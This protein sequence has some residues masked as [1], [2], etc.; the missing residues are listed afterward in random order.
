MGVR[1][2]RVNCPSANHFRKITHLI[3][4]LSRFYFLFFGSSSRCALLSSRSFSTVH[5]STEQYWSLERQIASHKIRSDHIYTRLCQVSCQVSMWVL[6]CTERF[7]FHQM[8]LCE[9]CWCKKRKEL[10]T[11]CIQYT[12]V[13]SGL[14]VQ[15]TK[16]PLIY[17]F[18]PAARRSNFVNPQAYSTV[19]YS[20]VA[21]LVR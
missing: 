14:S 15:N 10:L 5:T 13:Q 16:W 11:I 9:R 19:Q 1:H 4:F 8:W 17:W 18:G 3:S 2:E 7:A 21:P 12:T 20:I 6:H